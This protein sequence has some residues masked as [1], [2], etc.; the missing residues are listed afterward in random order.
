M[1]KGV[2]SKDIR[3]IITAI[4]GLA[5]DVKVILRNT[6]IFLQGKILDCLA[7]KKSWVTMKFKMWCNRKI[8][9]WSLYTLISHFIK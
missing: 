7:S 6:V 1:I 4:E 5:F 2:E 9:K 8:E 3:K